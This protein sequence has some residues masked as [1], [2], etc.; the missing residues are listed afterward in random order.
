MYKD[1]MIALD[2]DCNGYI[3]YTEFLVALVNKTK[4]LEEKNLKVAFNMFDTQKTGMITMNDIQG[5][6]D[7][8]G[9]KEQALWSS[10]MKEVDQDNDGQISY[11][12]LYDC[13]QKALQMDS[14][15]SDYLKKE[16]H[17]SDGFY[18]AQ[19]QGDQR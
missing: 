16:K 12:D 1:I 3:D 8:G 6:F 17:K 7:M 11:F 14:S 13:M 9:A 18:L 5:I 19:G 2:K 15:M 4:L 10:I